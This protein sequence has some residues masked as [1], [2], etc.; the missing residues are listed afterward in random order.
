[1]WK[2]F[3]WENWEMILLPFSLVGIIG[4]YLGWGSTVLFVLNCIALVPLSS[5]IGY[6]SEDVALHVN[7]VLG[8]LITASCG[9]SVE[10]VVGFLALNKE[11][12]E[13]VQ[14]LLV[15]SI[16]MNLLLVLG[17][18]FLLGGIKF[19]TQRFSPET[20]TINCA[21][22]MLCTLAMVIPTV[23]E[24]FN[25]I[26]PNETNTDDFMSPDNLKM[27][28]YGSIILLVMYAQ[29]LIFQL[30]TH[31]DIFVGD[32]EKRESPRVSLL[33]GLFT[34]CLAGIIAGF[35]SSNVVEVIE[36]FSTSLGMS[37]VFGGVIVLPIVVNTPELV[38]AMNAA[39][40][41]KMNLAVGIA[42]G[43]A[44][45]VIAFLVPSF[46]LF[47]W[48]IN[49]PMALDF[50]PFSIAVVIISVL[51]VA[52]VLRDG[53]STWITGSLLLSAYFCVG[54]GYFL[55]VPREHKL[56]QPDVFW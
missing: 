40:K 51:V 15:G 14:G 30:V 55:L 6:A 41:N 3:V 37:Q 24:E 46:V 12:V 22:L 48:I 39:Y 1:M 50:Q 32:D 52:I 28:R 7:Q 43:A 2:V 49:K 42:L 17:A 10:M 54:V 19:H 16:L 35:N 47:S 21:V 38:S 4:G 56:I 45:Q 18:S 26:G 8:G 9:N 23:F 33:G 5:M 13:V 27:S 34:I 11:I 44:T 53:Q 31:S 36:E 29:I 25:Q 20:V